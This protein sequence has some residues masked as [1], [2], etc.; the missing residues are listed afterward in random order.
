MNT[1]NT[2]IAEKTFFVFLRNFKSFLRVIR[3]IRVQKVFFVRFFATMRF[4][5]KNRFSEDLRELAVKRYSRR[6]KT[7]AFEAQTQYAQ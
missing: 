7:K 1:D 2:E 5:I 4:L 3:R 6:N